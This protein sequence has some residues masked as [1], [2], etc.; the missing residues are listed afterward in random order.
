MSVSELD[1][2]LKRAGFPGHWIDHQ[3]EHRMEDDYLIHELHMLKIKQGKHG[4]QTMSLV[5]YLMLSS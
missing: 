5:P 1:E 3:H 2:V 4:R